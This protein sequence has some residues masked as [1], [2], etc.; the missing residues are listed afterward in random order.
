MARGGR[1]AQ[2]F[3]DDGIGIGLTQSP[4]AQ[5][6]SADDGWGRFFRVDFFAASVCFA[7]SIPGIKDF[8]TAIAL[9][10][11]SRARAKLSGVGANSRSG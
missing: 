4:D 8:R 2:M 5:G 10:R 1:N 9:L 6:K 7:G 3:F 11:L